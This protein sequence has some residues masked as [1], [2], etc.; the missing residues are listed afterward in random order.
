M[1]ETKI[2]DFSRDLTP[3]AEK[4]TTKGKL[5]AAEKTLDKKADDVEQ[6]LK[7]RVSYEEQL[8]EAGISKDEAA[9]I[10]DAVLMKGYYSEEVKLTSRI[11]AR[12]RTRQYRDIQRAQT[13]IETQRPVYE[14]H[15]QAIYLRHALAGSLERFGKDTL[16]F[17]KSNANGDEVEKAFQERVT[18]VDQLSEPAMNLLYR[19]LFKF[20]Q[21]VLTVLSEGVIENF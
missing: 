10:I 14:D 11:S 7:P 21:K 18:Y 5:E 2:G 17:P 4:D 3:K 6:Q 1:E 12:F 16:N 13:I 20:D 15:K 8:K 9:E 19:M